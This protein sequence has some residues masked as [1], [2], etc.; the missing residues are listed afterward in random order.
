[1][2]RVLV[3]GISG[4]GKTTFA[5]A[6]SE[7]I[8]QPYHE[9]DAMFHG[10]N[11]QPIPT[12]EVDVERVTRHPSW[13]FDSDGYPQVR[14]LMWQRADTV[15]WVDYPR[16]VVMRQVVS[17]SARRARRQERI[18]N[19]NV[20]RFRDWLDPGHPIPWAWAQYHRR[21]AEILTRMADPC[22]QHPRFVHL[23]GRDEA[24]QFLTRLGSRSYGRS[25]GQT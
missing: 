13:V 10:P 15:I 5:K 9:L 24:E 11:W 17:R 22:H 14:N 16:H 21:R 1:V 8:G 7:Q 12:F 19:D 6:L 23:R 3:A 4:A 20:E 18:F 25:A 2:R